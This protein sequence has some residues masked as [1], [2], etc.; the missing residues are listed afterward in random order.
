MVGQKKWLANLCLAA[1]CAIS[2][3][4]V[5]AAEI[6]IKNIILLIGDGMG[7]Q[8]MGLLEAY[9]R[10]APNSRYQQGKT[11]MSHLADRGV[12]GLSMHNPASAIVV[13]SASSAT[14][15]ATGVPAGS[16]MIGL[17]VQGNSIETILEQAKKAGKAT[18]LVSDTRLTHATPASFAAHQP[19]RSLEN[20]IAENMLATAPDVMLS[21]G[22]RHWIPTD[23]GKP[24]KT[25]DQLVTLV[26][27]KISLKSKRKDNRNLL[28]E[29]K[30]AGYQLAFDRDQLSAANNNGKVLG[31]FSS[32][33]MLDGIAYSKAKDDP[34]RREPSLREMTK[35]ALAV[36]ANDPDGFFLM[37][38]GGQ[39]D[40]AGH[41]N[42]AGTMLHEMLKFDEA[43]AAVV[44]W[45]K[46]RDDTLVVLT[47]D[48]ETGSFGFSY[49]AANLPKAKALPGN[50]FKGIKFKPNFNFGSPAILDRLFAQQKSFNAMFAEFWTLS[51]DQQSAKALVKIINA[52]SEFKITEAQAERIL[53][54]EN[55]TYYQPDHKYLSL[56]QFPKV[57]D[58]KAFYVYGDE[59]KFNLLG[60]ELAEQQNVVWGTGTHTHT[61]VAVL[62]YGPEQLTKSFATIQHH[63]D[64]GRKL[65]SA[66][67]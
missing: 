26:G 9:A 15:L 61:P 11:A 42:D 2:V 27:D 39:I 23:A 67:R 16:E 20:K 7:P 56:K 50:A 12:I 30:Q 6:K 44:E 55:N 1:T 62:A 51:K 52:N 59:V 66:L 3:A 40:W 21:G 33:G 37:V 57:T 41:N 35:K 36:L 53:A 4:T 17:D 18:G 22:L 34:K 48:H 45:V 63:T 64:I 38:E 43:V 54:T 14:Q 29:A 49:S 32:S 10:Q 31:L 65:K 13:D 47:A 25:H 60:R 46:D 28:A 58:F 8:Q 19:H 5:D 24:G